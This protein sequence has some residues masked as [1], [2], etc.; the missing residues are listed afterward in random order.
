MNSNSI[1]KYDLVKDLIYFS[2]TQTPGLADFI[3]DY[4]SSSPETVESLIKDSQIEGITQ[5]PVSASNAIKSFLATVGGLNL[6][7]SKNITLNLEILEGI[8]I[9]NVDIVSKNFDKSKTY[10]SKNGTILKDFVLEEESSVI[11]LNKVSLIFSI[12]K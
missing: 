12:K 6:T 10:F 11:N 2:K 1:L 5:I 3:K 4:T 7:T 8:D 9:G